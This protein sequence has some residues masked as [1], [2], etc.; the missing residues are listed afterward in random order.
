MSNPVIPIPG[1]FRRSGADSEWIT[2]IEAAVSD[3]PRTVT[4]FILHAHITYAT[5]AGSPSA[6]VFVGKAGKPREVPTAAATIALTAPTS[7]Y[8]TA[9]GTFGA[10]HSSGN[11]ILIAVCASGGDASDVVYMSELSLELTE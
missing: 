4:G 11:P 7:G 1:N 9:S 5:S 6:S 2:E 10:D 8:L 3:L